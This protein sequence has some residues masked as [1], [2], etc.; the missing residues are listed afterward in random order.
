MCEEF[1]LAGHAAMLACLYFAPNSPRQG[2]LKGLRSSNREKAISGAK[3]AAWD[4]VHLSDFVRRIR[5]EIG[6]ESRQYI[7]ATFDS[8]LKALTQLTLDAGKNGVDNFENLSLALKKWWPEKDAD[9]IGSIFSTYWHQ[10]GDSTWQNKYQNY[11][12]HIE[13]FVVLGEEAL[14]AWHP[15]VES[16]SR[17]S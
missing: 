1:I 12:Q 8:G 17:K 16:V 14:R 7:L 3:N 5:G 15:G 9:D 4:I 11:P 6:E 13:K 10:T 2:L